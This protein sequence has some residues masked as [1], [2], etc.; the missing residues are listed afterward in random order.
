MKN[1]WFR[2][3]PHINAENFTLVAIIFVALAL[4]FVIVVILNPAK[5]T[6]FPTIRET[7]S[8]TS[9]TVMVLATLGL[10]YATFRMIRNSNEQEKRLREENRRMREEDRELNFKLRLLDEVRDWAREAVKLGFLYGRTKGKFEEHR[11]TDMIEDIAK[12]TD[13]SDMAAVVFK[14]ELEAP[15]TKAL[16]FVKNYKTPGILASKAY[17]DSLFELLKAVNKIK[18]RLYHENEAAKI[19]TRDLS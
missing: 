14:D 17:F 7:V 18:R 6:Q 15:V 3:K 2:L 12:T 1:W 13:I 10:V 16:G 4:I 8:A 5:F 19:K 9:T 11:V